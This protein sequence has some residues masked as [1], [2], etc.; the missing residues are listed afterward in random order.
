MRPLGSIAV[1]AVASVIVYLLTFTVLVKKPLTVGF[2][3]DALQLKQ[4]YAATIRRPKLVIIAGSNGLFSHRCETMEP[5][6]DMPCL[7]GAITAELG[8][9]YMLELGQRLIRPGDAVLLPLEYTEFPLPERRYIDAQGHPFRLTYDRENIGVLPPAQLG[10]ALFQFDLSY[11]IGALAEMALDAAGVRRRFSVETLTRHGDMRG[12]TVAKAERFR[13]QIAA[14]ESW[15]PKAA[16]FK[17]SRNAQT[18]IGRFLGWASRNDVRVIATMPTMFD[19]RLAEDALITQ[20]RSLYEGAGHAFFVLPNLNQ[21]PR[22]CFYDTPF[23]L[24]EE[25]Q[26]RHST[27]LAKALRPILREGK[28]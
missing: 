1:A 13:R 24:H 26:I 19:D 8:L 17:M 10:R 23:H 21:Y 12:H 27:S 9:A 16:A 25:C 11:L 7:N 22:S 3:A 2:I 15:L 18:I 5:I 4:D 6:L 28:P 14:S 20:L